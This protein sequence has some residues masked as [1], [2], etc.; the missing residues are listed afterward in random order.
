MQSFDTAAD[1]SRQLFT[2]GTIEE[3]IFQRQIFKRGLAGDLIQ[4]SV[5]AA[6]TD[7][8]T[9]EDLRSL[10]VLRTDTACATH[11]LLGCTCLS[12]EDISDDV[13][14]EASSDDVLGF[15]PA[16]QVRPPTVRAAILAD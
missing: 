10:F 2:T 15:L 12:G 8:F 14:E 5:K 6:K 11:D 1:L 3:C 9:A 13:S 7:A 16:S 4:D